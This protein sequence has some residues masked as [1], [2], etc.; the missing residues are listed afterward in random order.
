MM[1]SESAPPGDAAQESFLRRFGRLTA[2]YF[3]S[4]EKRRARGL[5]AGVLALTLL[6]IAIQVRFNIWNRDFFNALETRD[7]A[8]FFGQMGL[9]LALT[10]GSMAT[11]VFQL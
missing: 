10:L 3:N 2:E 11:A 7:R 5:A 4:A 1:A 6:Q 9:F 8:A